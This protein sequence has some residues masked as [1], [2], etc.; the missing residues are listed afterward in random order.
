MEIKIVISDGG[1]AGAKETSISVGEGGGAA[2]AS[3]APT[4]SVFPSAQDRAGAIDAGPAPT[5]AS[6]TGG[7][8]PFVGQRAANVLGNA[9]GTTSTDESGGAAPG[10]GKGMETSTQETQHG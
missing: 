4:G 8:Q 5:S 6:A 2:S 9:G 10:S 3:A 7:P 1:A